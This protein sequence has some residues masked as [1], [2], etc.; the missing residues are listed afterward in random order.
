MSR[1]C[2]QYKERRRC[3]IQILDNFWDKSFEHKVAKKFADK[4][5]R[6]VYRRF[7][8]DYYFFV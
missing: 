8:R 5:R 6:S 2:R 4:L 1:R 3:S 7:L